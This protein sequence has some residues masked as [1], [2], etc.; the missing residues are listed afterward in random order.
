MGVGTHPLQGLPKMINLME[1]WATLDII[2]L[3]ERPQRP[4]QKWINPKMNLFSPVV[5]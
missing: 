1:Y 2:R 5:L 4:M 3:W